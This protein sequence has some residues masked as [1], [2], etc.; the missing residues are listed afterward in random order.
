[1]SWSLFLYNRLLRLGTPVLATVI[2]FQTAGAGISIAG[3]G[4]ATE[5]T[6][7]IEPAPT[8]S[9]APPEQPK[10]PVPVDNY[11]KNKI[12]NIEKNVD[13]VHEDLEQKILEQAV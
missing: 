5:P 10:D 6:P 1:M 7:V 11:L 13:K 3:E 9:P 2:L 4:P 12:T 8:T